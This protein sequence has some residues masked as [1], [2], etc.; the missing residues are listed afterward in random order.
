MRLPAL[1]LGASSGRADRGRLW[2]T[3]R[4]LV[5]HPL[6]ALGTLHEQPPRIVALRAREDTV[7]SRARCLP[8]A[9]L[10][11]YDSNANA[12]QGLGMPSAP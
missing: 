1:Q 11:V 8:R 4:L 3:S 5:R 6:N 10:W 2:L 12:H 9:L 7:G